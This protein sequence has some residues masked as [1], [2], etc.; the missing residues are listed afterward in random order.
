MYAHYGSDRRLLTC[1]RGPWK[2]NGSI[3]GHDGKFMRVEKGV[4]CDM[5]WFLSVE[6]KT[7][8]SSDLFSLDASERPRRV[9]C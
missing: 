2:E 8:N 1:V 6:R 4:L 7:E 5:K 9:A 3:S